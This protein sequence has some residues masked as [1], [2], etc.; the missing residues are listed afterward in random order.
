MNNHLSYS[1]ANLN[2]YYIDNISQNPFYQI[3]NEKKTPKNINSLNNSNI[4]NICININ[5]INLNNADKPNSF[6]DQILSPGS[7]E[8]HSNLHHNEDDSSYY[9]QLSLNY[10]LNKLHQKPINYNNYNINGS[11]NVNSKSKKLLILDLDE[12]LVHSYLKALP[13][14]LNHIKPDFVFKIKFNSVIHNV[15]VL[16]RPHVEEFLDAMNKLFNVVIFTASI[17]EYANPLL[18]Q[19]DPK[20]IIKQRFY[21]NHCKINKNGKYIKDLSIIHSNL[22][23]VILVDNNPIS[24]SINQQNGIPILTWQY[25]KSDKELLKLIPVLELLS[26]VDD[27]RSYIPRFVEL[28]EIN[29]TKVKV[30]MNEFDNEN[31]QKKYLRSR[32]R[33]NTKILHERKENNSDQRKSNLNNS[34][35][36]ENIKKNINNSNNNLTRSQIISEG[37]TNKYFNNNNSNQKAKSQSNNNKNSA[38]NNKEKK[39]NNKKKS[40]EE[41][42]ESKFKDYLTN[43]EENNK[44]EH[45][46]KNL[47]NNSSY[48]RDNYLQKDI[49][50]NN[51]NYSTKTQNVN[52]SSSSNNR[53]EFKYFD[54]VSQKLH[55]DRNKKFLETRLNINKKVHNDYTNNNYN[56][57]YSNN[58]NPH[59]RNNSIDVKK[60]YNQL[61]NNKKDNNK[62]Y[63]RNNYSTNNS[64]MYNNFNYNNYNNNRNADNKTLYNIRGYSTDQKSNQN[65]SLNDSNSKKVNNNINNNNEYINH[66]L[67]STNFYRPNHFYRNDNNI[68]N[69]NGFNNINRNFKDNFDFSN[70]RY[71]NNNLYNNNQYNNG[72]DNRP[73]INYNNNSFLQPRINDYRNNSNNLKNDYR[74]EWNDYYLNMALR[75]N[76]Y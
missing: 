19:L 25:D 58:K 76:Y 29:Y 32:P 69:N 9:N 14:N 51:N 44:K 17:K 40:S 24:Y 50:S 12:T 41:M 1:Y 63:V 55:D 34:V 35:K 20:K 36:K 5:T 62:H 3:Y 11:Q 53:F 7:N 8:F 61:S 72:Y 75:K 13:N 48:K 31:N 67:T 33:S 38:K 68:Y 66:S 57:N 21:R 4:N 18:D 60:D 23:N 74:S 26:N 28:N 6:V 45:E 73:L 65:H 70:Y 37:K 43:N 46:R 22:K 59:Q 56:T 39:D 30:L 49:I 2:R 27:V 64:N 71:Y 52:N 54:E 42:I 15:F 10:K 16:K 47:Y